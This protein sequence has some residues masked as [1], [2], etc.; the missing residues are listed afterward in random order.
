MNSKKASVILFVLLMIFSSAAII[1][2]ISD[3]ASNAMR[4]RITATKDF[5]LR[6]DAFS[7]LNATIAILEEYSEIDG[8]IYSYLQGWQ[9]P[10]A[11][12]R[13]QLPSG[14]DVEVEIIDESGK[15]PLRALP[16]DTTLAK[17]LEALGLNQR[18]AEE[19]ADLIKDWCDKNDNPSFNGAEYEDY[20]TGATEPLNRPMETFRELMYVK[21]A[22]K[23]F[24]D[25]NQRPTEFYKKF[26]SIF[27]LEPFKKIN[28]NSASQDVLYVLMEAEEKD[29][30]ATLYSA[31]RGE[32]GSI[33]DGITWCKNA[34]ELANR[35]VVDYPTNMTTFTAELLKINITI[36]RGWAVYRLTAYYT[37]ASIYSQMLNTDSSSSQTNRASSSNRRSSNKNSSTSNNFD[38]AVVNKGSKSAVKKGTFKV[39][40]IIAN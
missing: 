27:S 8:G 21:D 28:L 4:V 2:A 14:S 30:D 6:Y 19:Y 11:D 25:E 39:V 29:Y 15:I 3:Y 5:Q 7:A 9:K 16:N 22:N 12:N 35:G 38:N 13:I 23:I 18:E 37:D 32:I 20:D 34:T 40:K 33:V 36:K 26:T 24:F 17:M 10:F 1:V 31:L